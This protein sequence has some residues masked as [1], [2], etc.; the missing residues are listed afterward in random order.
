MED[1][2]RFLEIIPDEREQ[3]KVL[4]KLKDIIVIVLFAK[5]TNADDWQDI[6]H[7]AIIHEEL[8]REYMQVIQSK[9]NAMLSNGE[10]EKLK[11]FLP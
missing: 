2:L 7:F 6:H 3:H 5:L 1:L 4:H 11:K 9:F 8:L 10:G